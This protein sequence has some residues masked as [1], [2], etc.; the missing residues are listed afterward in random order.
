MFAFTQGLVYVDG[1][2]FEGTGLNGESDIRKVD[3][4][5]GKVLAYSS[6]DSRYFGEGITIWNN[7]LIQLTWTSEIGF[8]YDKFTFKEKGTFRYK[9]EGWGLTHDGKHLIM[10]DGSAVIR[11]LDPETFKEIRTIAVNSAGRP[12]RFLNELEFVKGEIYANVWGTNRIARISPQTGEVLRWIDLDLLLI[13]R[14]GIF[15]S[16][17]SEVLNG[18]AYDQQR[19]RLFVT[20]K[21]WPHIFEIKV[22][23]M[24][25][26]K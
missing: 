14:G 13:P 11:Y 19:D 26:T 18:I 6:L 7:N 22:E 16:G 4:D 23:P 21:W 9:G 1:V 24:R 25:E 15:A 3:L 8:L 20:G 2:L 10:S 17:I 5:T 12:V